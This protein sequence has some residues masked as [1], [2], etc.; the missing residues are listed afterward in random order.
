MHKRCIA[1]L[2]ATVSMMSLSA[3]GG[4]DGPYDDYSKKEIIEYL[5]RVEQSRD[6]AYDRID[7]LELMLKGVRGEEVEKPVISE[8][9]DGTGRETLHSIDGFIKLP[10]ELTYPQ[11]ISTYSSSGISVS[12]QLQLTPS[13]SWIAKVSG[14]TTYLENPGLNISGQFVVGQISPPAGEDAIR[15]DDLK[16]YVSEF[17]LSMPPTKIQHI[18]IYLDDLKVGD[19]AVASTFVDEKETQIM[20]GMIGYG[21]FCAT[22]IFA[23]EGASDVTK[24]EMIMSIMRNATIHGKKLSIE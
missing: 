13:S 4:G 23:Y 24:N 16:D 20:C 17:F 8:F 2:L 22:Y 6:D 5:E 14:T 18:S 3:C 10:A 12:S 15:I 1:L 11:S 19:H 21:D 9:S 7:E